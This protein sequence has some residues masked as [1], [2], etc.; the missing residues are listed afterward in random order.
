MWPGGA[1]TGGEQ[2]PDS[3][4]HCCAGFSISTTIRRRKK[5]T[6]PNNNIKHYKG[7]V[8][9]KSDISGALGPIHYITLKAFAMA[10]EDGTKCK[11]CFGGPRM[12]HG[13]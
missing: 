5:Q 1:G 10:L 13:H 4:H 2:M 8:P 12:I 9:K 7:R 11:T 3:G 6:T